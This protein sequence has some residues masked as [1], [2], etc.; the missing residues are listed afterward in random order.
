MLALVFFTEVFYGSNVGQSTTSAAG[1][2]ALTSPAGSSVGVAADAAARLVLPTRAAALALFIERM[3]V[4]VLGYAVAPSEKSLLETKFGLGPLEEDL[5]QQSTTRNKAS[6][7]SSGKG[8]VLVQTFRC[9]Y[10]LSRGR[11]RAPTSSQAFTGTSTAG[12]Y[13][14]RVALMMSLDA[15]DV[16]SIDIFEPDDDSSGST[17]GGVQG[18]GSKASNQGKI[19]SQGSGSNSAG[20]SEVLVRIC[21]SLLIAAT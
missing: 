17:S 19:P 16:L 21:Q 7:D 15:G 18:G 9:E 11:I 4:N 10:V 13:P 2:A 6:L 14:K 12:K 8:T 3:L 1:A 20:I 5:G